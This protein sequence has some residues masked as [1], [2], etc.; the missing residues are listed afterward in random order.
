MAAL[1]GLHLANIDDLQAISDANLQRR[2]TAAC[3]AQR[4]VDAAARAYAEWLKTRRAVPTIKAIVERAEQVRRQEIERTLHDLGLSTSDGNGSE[5]GNAAGAL[6]EQKLDLMT[7]AIVK[8]IL[9]DPIAYL[10][11]ADDTEASA[12]LVGRIFGLEDA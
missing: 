12:A 7:A 8:K 6:L 5:T 4:I 10:R 9:H 1:P 11:F 3:D 2:E